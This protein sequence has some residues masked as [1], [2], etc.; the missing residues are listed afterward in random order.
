MIE[1]SKPNIAVVGCGYWGKNI[2]RTVH[3][4]GVLKTV[5][6]SDQE[7]QKKF[8]GNLGLENIGFKSALSNK[9]ISG[10]MI[11]TSA[12]T[13]YDVA[14]QCLEYGKDVFIEKPICLDLD[15]AFQLGKK[16][17]ESKSILMVGHL[18]HYHDH[19]IEMK[20]ILKSKK[21]GEIKRI[22]STRKSFGIIRDYED[23][24]WSFAPHDIS[25]VLSLSE[26]KKYKNLNLVRKSFFGSNTDKANIFF[27][28][29][30]IDVEIEVDWSSAKK[31]Q[32]IEVYCENG[33][34]IFEDSNTVSAEKLYLIDAEYSIDNL[35]TKN[36]LKPKY[37]TVN[38][39]NPLKN[40]C[41][42]FIS[43]INT[44][45]QPITCFEEAYLVLEV[46]LKLQKI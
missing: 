16:S 7:L 8:N 34:L 14:M 4:L 42:A 13:H 3:E 1:S 31:E 27:E 22:K 19:F 39:G 23:V 25:M 37:I 30:S 10:M 20:N 33:V 29:D 43:S 11:A 32:K 28:L 18:L 40:E 9:D 24:I 12:N 5:V 38:S 17:K 45:K 36:I 15:Q 35:S 41:N 44:R 6:D 2:V 46:L 21:L 26:N